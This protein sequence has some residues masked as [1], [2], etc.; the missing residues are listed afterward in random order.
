MSLKAAGT[1]STLIVD[2]EPL[3]RE[4]L[5]FLLKDFPEID[6]LDTASNGLEAIRM[7]ENLEPDLVFL[8]VQMPGLDGL[9]VIQKL[10][11][12]KIPLPHF[13]LATA[14]DQYAVEAFR[15]EA[16]DYLLKPIEKERLTLSIERAAKIVEAKQAAESKA[17][18]A[19]PPRSSLQRTK[20]LVRSG[21]RNLVVDANDL[22][23]ATI[24]D[25]LITVVTTQL[26][27]QLN[28]RT[29]EELQSNLDPEIF[30]RVH[31]SFLV[32]INRIREVVPWF[33]SS[34]QLKMDDK[35][36]TEIPVS[37]IQTK[38]LRTLLKL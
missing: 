29:I 19:Q 36:Q 38:R 3:A 13:V 1:I 26:E 31:R 27:G 22:I 37:R 6:V 5:A 34:F 10:Q 32:N 16:T 7:I 2:D 15:L 12:K 33:K 28:Y 11:E 14:F 35:K 8:D 9:G 21:Q 17:A 30:W 23:Y 4:E 24:D 25:G 18:E 20:L